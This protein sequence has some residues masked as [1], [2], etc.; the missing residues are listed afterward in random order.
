MPAH[1][2]VGPFS[3]SHRADVIPAFGRGVPELAPFKP[4]CRRR[5]LMSPFPAA[6]RLVP[7]SR[8]APE[9][10]PRS[11]GRRAFSGIALTPLCVAHAGV[12]APPVSPSFEAGV[13]VL[14]TPSIRTTTAALFCATSLTEDEASHV[15]GKHLRSIFSWKMPAPSTDRACLLVARPPP[16][17]FYKYASQYEPRAV[18]TAA[19][20]PF[21]F[22]FLVF[23]RNPDAR[24]V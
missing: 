10:N 24:N 1:E 21:S 23:A 19:V 17:G 8:H 9:T 11:V 6:I 22:T 20:M 3:C 7:R 5:G 14:L 4:C 16:R 13:P 12:L 18:A 15:D 2:T